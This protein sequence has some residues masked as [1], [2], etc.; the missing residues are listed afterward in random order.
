MSS[1]STTTAT[2]PQSPTEEHSSA[3]LVRALLAVVSRIPWHS[4]FQHL[5]VVEDL[6]KWEASLLGSEHLA[7][8]PPASPVSAPTVQSFIGTSAEFDYQKL[9]AAMLDEQARRDKVA[10]EQMAQANEAVATTDQSATPEFVGSG[11]SHAAAAQPDA[12]GGV[13]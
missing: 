10:S 5:G 2:E 12:P 3:P 6:R 9:A 1:T 4:E 8:M 11:P 7:Q 13:F